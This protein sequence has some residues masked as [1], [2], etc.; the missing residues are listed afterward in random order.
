VLWIDHIC[1]R[2]DLQILFE[3]RLR[4]IGGEGS[5]WCQLPSVTCSAL[6]YICS[7]AALIITRY[8]PRLFQ[9]INLHLLP[10]NFH[11]FFL[12]RTRSNSPQPSSVASQS[13]PALQNMHDL[14]CTAFCTHAAILKHLNN[15]SHPFCRIAVGAC[16]THNAPIP[17]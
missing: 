1:G 13:V 8:F 3:A 14:P 7:L 9:G 2:L 4:E 11:L 15:H 16:P 17:L 12:M 10:Q 5:R 6:L